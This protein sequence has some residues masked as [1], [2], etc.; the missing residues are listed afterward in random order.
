MTKPN[1]LFPTPVW[2][3][4]LEKYKDINEKMY[5]YIKLKQKIDE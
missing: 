5:S 4:Q 1:L 2:T 3:I